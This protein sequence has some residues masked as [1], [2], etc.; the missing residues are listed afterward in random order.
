MFN[1]NP[2]VMKWRKDMNILIYL[3]VAALIGWVATD[4]MHDRSNLLLNIIIAVLGAFLAGY[5]LSPIFNVGTINQA[6]T[7]PTMLVTLLG[8]IILLA[9]IRIFRRVV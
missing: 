8:A 6:I 7:I 5:F 9:V 1:K 3:I 2:G 4:L